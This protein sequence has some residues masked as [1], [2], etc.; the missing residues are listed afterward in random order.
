MKQQQF[1][2]ELRKNLT[3]LP[4]Q[5]VND[6]V[7]DQEEMIREAIASG[8][9]EE[10][11]LQALGDPKVLAATLV[12]QNRID[13]AQGA[14]SLL[15]KA[16]NTMSAL[17]AFL[18]LA[19]LNFF[20]LVGPFCVGA[21]VLFAFWVTAF[22]LF[23]TFA[24]VG[25]WTMGMMFSAGSNALAH[26]GTSFFML[27]CIGVS[28][29]FGMFLVWATKVFLTIILKYLKWNLKVMESL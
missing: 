25:A 20:I 29:I 23:M 24:G 4:Q 14:Q 27:G 17:M 1:I 8:R 26:L 6:I 28:L 21:C 22:T 3:L 12:A 13:Q 15:P 18:A 16:R 9:N 5:E 11:V 7:R 2:S 19:P 10:S